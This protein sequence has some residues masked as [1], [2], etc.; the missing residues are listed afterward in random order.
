MSGLSAFLVPS[1]HRFLSSTWAEDA[2]G[3]EEWWR[4]VAHSVVGYHFGTSS[5]GSPGRACDMVLA[6]SLPTSSPQV[7]TAG[8]CCWPWPGRHLMAWQLPCP[9]LPASGPGSGMQG[10]NFPWRL[11][12]HL[13]F[14]LT[15]SGISQRGLQ[16]PPHPNPC[17][18]WGKKGVL[19]PIKYSRAKSSI[20][21]FYAFRVA[22]YF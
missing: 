4:G 15:W 21:L 1:E 6:L 19:A 13:E 14:V 18:E 10:S 3:S 12:S 16:C 8:M 22:V 20:F 11:V 9:G 17:V 5:Q 7:T 2:A